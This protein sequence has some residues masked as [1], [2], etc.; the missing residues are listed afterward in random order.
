MV[1]FCEAMFFMWFLYQYR[2]YYYNMFGIIL[3][4]I[5]TI[6]DEIASSSGKWNVKHKTEGIYTFGFL[7]YFWISILFLILV[8][9]RGEFIFNMQSLPLLGVLLVLEIAQTYASLHA[10]VESE[11]STLGFLMVGT[12]PLLLVVDMFLGYTIP[13][14]NIVGVSLIVLSLLFLFINHGLSKKG[15]GYVLFSTVNSVATLSIFKYLITH[16]NAVESQQLIAHV[17]LAF[18]LFGMAVWKDNVNPLTLIFRKKFLFQ[19]VSRSVAVALMSFAYLYAPAS[20]IAGARRGS[21]A[22]VSVISGEKYFHEK[23]I[24]VKIV[25]FCLMVGGLVFLVI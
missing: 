4:T 9:V 10:I 20:I 25:S 23:H 1:S 13:L 24:L 8:F 7:N 22:L 14:G 16:Y 21:S 3:V 12:V 2:L 17:V 19:S 11:R 18:F 15:I 5:G 6:F